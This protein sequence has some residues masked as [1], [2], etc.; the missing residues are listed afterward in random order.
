VII[1]DKFWPYKIL[2]ILYIFGLV[3]LLTQTLLFPE[4]EIP[5]IGASGAVAGVM[6]AYFIMFP[7]AY[8]KTLLII[9]IYITVVDIPAVIF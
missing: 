4:A 6:G 7:Y 3:A 5:T 9:I 2:N 8:V 1:E